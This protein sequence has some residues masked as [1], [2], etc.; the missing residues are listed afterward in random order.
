MGPKNQLQGGPITPLIGVTTPVTP[1]IR[2]FT[3]VI[4]PFTTSRGPSCITIKT[5]HGGEISYSLAQWLAVPITILKEMN[6]EAIF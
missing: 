4:T 1:N 2:Q 3:G 6:Q 5:K